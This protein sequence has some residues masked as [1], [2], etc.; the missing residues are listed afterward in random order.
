MIDQDQVQSAAEPFKT[1][2]DFVAA[3]VTIGVL[4]GLITW[5]A[6]IATAVWAV[7]RAMN[8]IHQWRMR[9]RGG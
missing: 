9:K 5:T 1:V 3:S 6:A 7:F 4:S 8:E 2:V